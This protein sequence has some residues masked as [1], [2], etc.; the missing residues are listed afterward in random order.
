MTTAAIALAAMQ[1][2]PVCWVE[3]D[4]S[5]KPE[6]YDTIAQAISAEARDDD[7]AAALITIGY[8]ESTFALRVQTG[9]L[10]GK[11]SGLWQLEGRGKFVGFGLADTQR[12]AHAAVGA[13]RHSWQCGS[14]FA[15]RIT[16]YAGRACGTVWPGLETRVARF[17]YVRWTIAKA[18]AV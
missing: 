9:E 8:S 6:Q 5:R 3:R 13:W 12:S 16:A 2:L 4:D 7:E 1:A 17:R 10:K 14:T 18:E 11:A 15:D